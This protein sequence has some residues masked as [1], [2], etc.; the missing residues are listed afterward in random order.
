[1][2]KH[3]PWEIDL[4]AYASRD[5]PAIVTAIF[6]KEDYETSLGLIATVHQ[7]ANNT[8]LAI[9]DMIPAEKK[10]KL[11]ERHKSANEFEHSHETVGSCILLEWLTHSK[12]VVGP[13]MHL[14]A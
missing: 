4:P 11:K 7:F 14:L 8:H 12:L 13:A 10:Q 3:L 2:Y 9:F 1:M 5:S 6:K